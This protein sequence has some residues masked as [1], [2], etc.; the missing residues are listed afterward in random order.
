MA[1]IEQENQ[2]TR[3]MLAQQSELAA[4]QAQEAAFSR[5]H[6]DYGDA[7]KHLIGSELEEFRMG[8][9]QATVARLNQ[10]LMGGDQQIKQAV[11]TLAAVGMDEDAAI[12]TIAEQTYINGR[13]AQ[14]REAARV[15]NKPVPELGY[16]FAQRRGWQ[17][18]VAT[19][20]H[21][22]APPQTAEQAEAALTRVRQAKQISRGAQSLSEM[23]DDR[24]ATGAAPDA[25]GSAG[26]GRQG[27]RRDVRP[28]PDGGMVQ[29]DMTIREILMRIRSKVPIVDEAGNGQ[30]N[31]WAPNQVTSK[32]KWYLGPLAHEGSGPTLANVPNMSNGELDAALKKDPQGRW[33]RES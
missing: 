26:N 25:R 8:P 19:T 32:R 14:L 33:F 15:M 4:V 16:A 9:K 29:R 18:Q 1:R 6:P 24:A 11:D 13:A 31:D 21:P 5:E 3:A 28:R 2:Q 10:A 30:D 22:S 20:A 7:I 12:G 23:D 27:H 17:P